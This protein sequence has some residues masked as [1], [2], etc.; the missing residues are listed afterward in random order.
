VQVTVAG[1]LVTGLTA[2][3]VFALQVTPVADEISGPVFLPAP[4]L[5][6]LAI[7]YSPPTVAEKVTGDPYVDGFVPPVRVS[8]VFEVARVML[9]LLL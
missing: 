9:K 7:P 5:P 8:E 3:P 1:R 2:Q 4:P 6:V